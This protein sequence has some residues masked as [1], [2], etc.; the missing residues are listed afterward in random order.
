MPGRQIVAGDCARRGLQLSQ[1]VQPLVVHGGLVQVE[2][3]ERGHQW[4]PAA[5]KVVV[6]CGGVVAEDAIKARRALYFRRFG[7]VLWRGSHPVHRL[8][9]SRCCPVCAVHREASGEWPEEVLEV[10]R[11]GD[12][13]DGTWSVSFNRGTF[14]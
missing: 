8:Q 10:G 6:P 1:D 7:R 4:D 3:L 5:A 2:H 13:E 9:F 12:M 11:E 14:I